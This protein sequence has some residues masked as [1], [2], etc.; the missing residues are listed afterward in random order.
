MT[1]DSFSATLGALLMFTG[2]D[3]NTWGNNANTAVFQVFEDSIANVLTEVVTGGALDLSGS[4]PPAAASQVRYAAIIF[5]GVLGSAQSI[6]VPNLTKFWWIQNTTSG[7]F[8]L[9]I[10]T[11]SGSASTAIPQNSGW[12]LV[13]CDGANVITVS[14]FN[15]KQIQMPDG[16][17]SAPPFSNITEPNSGWYRAGTQDWRLS[18]NGADVVQFTGP[19]ASSPSFNSLVPPGTVVA[20]D[21]ILAPSGWVQLFGQAVSRPVAN[22]GS[23]DTYKGVWGAITATCVGSTNG[24]TSVTGLTTDMRGKGLNKA[25]VEGTGISLGT[26]ITFTGATTATLSAVSGTH[27]GQTLTILPFGQGDG[28]T[29]FNVRDG[30]G[31]PMTGRGDM[32][33]TDRLVITVAGGNYDGTLLATNRAANDVPGG[34]QNLTLTQAQLPAFKPGIQITDPGHAHTQQVSG[35][36]G[37]QVSVAQGGNGAGQLGNIASNTTGITAAFSSNLGSGA[38]TPIMN[39]AGITNLIMKL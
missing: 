27:A 31:T 29:T 24:N 32:G 36:T 12:Q 2:N 26:T 20:S 19:G 39:P 4:P 17:V 23:I 15:S 33:G 38:T 1:A 9:T 11:P 3:N 10:K 8:A 5:S 14:P 6:V 37:G 13:Q 16:S 25:F 22:G 35:T 34:A 18:I 30:R 7:A 28:S 21:S